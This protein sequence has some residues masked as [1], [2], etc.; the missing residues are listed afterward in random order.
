MERPT[1]RQDSPPSGA[2]P[3][4]LELSMAAFD[5]VARLAGSMFT[6]AGASI[7]LVHDGEIW[8]SRYSDELPTEDPITKAV[9]AS[10]KLFWVEDGR[11]D[12][13][14]A[15]NPMVTGPPFLRFC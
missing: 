15:D 13:R 9:L 2:V 5:R 10:G 11:L 3:F 1:G 4:G 6:A 12:P 8:R 14:V 7:I